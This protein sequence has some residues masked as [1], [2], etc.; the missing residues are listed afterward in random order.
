MLVE[1]EELNGDNAAAFGP[2]TSNEID[3]GTDERGLF[4]N[5]EALELMIRE[6]ASFQRHCRIVEVQNDAFGVVN[7][8]VLSLGKGVDTASLGTSPKIHHGDGAPLLSLSWSIIGKDP[9]TT[10]PA[11]PPTTT[12]SRE[13]AAI[14]SLTEVLRRLETGDVHL[15]K[16]RQLKGLLDVARLRLGGYLDDDS[17]TVTEDEETLAPTDDE[18]DL[19]EPKRRKPQTRNTPAKRTCLVI[20]K[21][22]R[23]A[24]R[25]R[26]DPLE[27]VVEFLD[28]Q[29]K[30]RRSL[31][32]PIQA[33]I[34]A[35]TL[36]DDATLIEADPS[37]IESTVVEEDDG[38]HEEEKRSSPEEDSDKPFG[39]FSVLPPEVTVAIAAQL[40]AGE[41]GR[42]E[43]C[44][45]A[46]R[47]V[48]GVV[49]MAVLRVKRF[50]YGVTTLPLLHRDTWPKVLQ[51]WEWT[52]SSRSLSTRMDGVAKAFD[53]LALDL[54]LHGP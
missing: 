16:L 13:D 52:R 41:L 18:D 36:A 4:W 28:D 12:S 6:L 24:K 27:H 14:E 30:F 38:G 51:R 5:P 20:K 44:C 49:E 7:A 39:R 43:C 17:K 46:A 11:E 29:K 2:P 9:D 32:E 3:D 21:D 26:D 22:L 50:Q 31:V 42:L 48:P 35:V 37:V 25:R 10:M 53:S 34:E 1:S 23:D 45:R 40:N 15:G 47:G 54:S 19:D 8:E 33:V